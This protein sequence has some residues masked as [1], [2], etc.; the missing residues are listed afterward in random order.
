MTT[1]VKLH[2]HYLM[3]LKFTVSDTKK[4]MILDKRNNC[5]I[6]WIVAWANCL[7]NGWHSN[8]N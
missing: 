7:R 1:N 2:V 5:S 4:R 3:T 6:V 8:S